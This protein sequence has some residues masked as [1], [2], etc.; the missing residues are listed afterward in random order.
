MP[1]SDNPLMSF[2]AAGDLGLG[3]A[4]A[5]DAA[6]IAEA[7]RKRRMQQSKDLANAGA[8]GMPS[9]SFQALVGANIP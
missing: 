5:E 1:M 9:A 4:A 2:N 7:A 3:R 6:S 8:G